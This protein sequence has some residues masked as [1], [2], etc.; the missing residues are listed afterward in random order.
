MRRSR[1]SVVAISGENWTSNMSSCALS[2]RVAAM[3]PAIRD[4]IRAATS[5]RHVPSEIHEIPEVPRTLSGKSVE[6]AAAKVLR[7]E[8]PKNRDALANPAALDYLKRF[9]VNPGPDASGGS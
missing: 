7:G 5:P 9:A 4:A 6:I 1:S 3:S 8:E 2:R